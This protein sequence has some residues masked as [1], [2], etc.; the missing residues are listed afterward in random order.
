MGD[1]R[2]IRGAIEDQPHCR[3]RDFSSDEISQMPRSGVRLY[4][5]YL[6]KTPELITFNVIIQLTMWKF[7]PKRLCIVQKIPPSVR[8][9]SAE[10]LA[11]QRKRYN[12]KNKFF[13][14][15]AISVITLQCSADSYGIQHSFINDEGPGCI[16]HW[17]AWRT[18]MVGIGLT[19]SSPANEGPFT[20]YRN[21]EK[22]A[23]VSNSTWFRDMDTVAGRAYSSYS[24]LLGA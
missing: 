8:I 6:Q 11:P 7:Q 19:C 22:I 16:L 15:I 9:V 18:T 2:K 21:G 4:H 24:P 14:L 5:L 12:M 3:R 13:A 23:V 17:E 10:H 1:A 20:I